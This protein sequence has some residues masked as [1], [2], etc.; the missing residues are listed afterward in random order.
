MCGIDEGD[1]DEW[2]VQNSALYVMRMRIM[3]SR[4]DLGQE[5]GDRKNINKPKWLRLRLTHIFVGIFGT[6]FLARFFVCGACAVCLEF[7]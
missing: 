5:K 1:E 3:S 6:K 4:S 7:Q 2:G